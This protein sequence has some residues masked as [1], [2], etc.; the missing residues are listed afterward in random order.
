MKFAVIIGV[1]QMSFGI[2]LKGLNAI[3]FKNSLDL[4]F[5]FIPQ[6]IFL[7]ILFGYMNICIFIKWATPWPVNSVTA[8][9]IINLLMNI[10]LGGG[11]LGNDV[12]TGYTPSGEPI[13][14]PVTPLFGEPRGPQ[15]NFHFWVLVI[16]GICVPIMLLPKP[17]LLY[18][19]DKNSNHGYDQFIEEV[20][21]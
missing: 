14:T 21:K 13:Y 6:I 1:L 11:T 5:E 4:I 20:Y 3:Y 10:F 18:L 7:S 15:E 2:V 17:I 12:I 9:S 8:P 16:S 19:R